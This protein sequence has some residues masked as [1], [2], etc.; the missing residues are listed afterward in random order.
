[1]KPKKPEAFALGNFPC[2]LIANEQN[3]GAYYGFPMIPSTITTGPAGMKMA[4]HYPGAIT[5]PDD[6]DR[7]IIADDV[8]LFISAKRFLFQS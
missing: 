7:N 2:W 3:N 1:M 5:D 4:L 6:V 8:N